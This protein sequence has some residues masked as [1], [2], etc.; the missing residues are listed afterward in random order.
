MEKAFAL[1]LFRFSRKCIM[2]ATNRNGDGNKRQGFF[3]FGCRVFIGSGKSTA[4]S[5]REKRE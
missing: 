1:F 5:L 3:P 4:G 2:T